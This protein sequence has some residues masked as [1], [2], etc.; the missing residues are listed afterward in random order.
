ML[1]KDKGMDNRKGLNK[2]TE[3]NIKILEPQIRHPQECP[4]TLYYYP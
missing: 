1:G 2:R 4:K 3:T